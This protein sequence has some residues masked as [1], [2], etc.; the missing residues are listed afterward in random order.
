M[1]VHFGQIALAAERALPAV[2]QLP[3][4]FD[5]VPVLGLVDLGTVADQ[6]PGD[7]HRQRDALDDVVVAGLLAVELEQGVVAGPAVEQVDQRLLAPWRRPCRTGGG[8]AHH[9]VGERLA[10]QVAAIF[11]GRRDRLD[12]PCVRHFPTSAPQA[13]GAPSATSASSSASRASRANSTSP[14]RANG[15]ASRCSWPEAG[16]PAARAHQAAVA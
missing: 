5:D 10:A 11:V 3:Q 4:P 14:G 2:D 7:D 15:G 1:V 13:R 8:G 16:T 9:G 6:A 12:R